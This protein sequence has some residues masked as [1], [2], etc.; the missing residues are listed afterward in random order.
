MR[1]DDD[2]AVTVGIGLPVEAGIFAL[3]PIAGADQDWIDVFGI[4]SVR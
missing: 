4:E 1:I 3:D 2:P